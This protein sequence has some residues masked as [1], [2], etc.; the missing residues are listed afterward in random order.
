MKVEVMRIG[1][2]PITV[3]LDCDETSVKSVFSVEGSGRVLGYNSLSLVAAA[4]EQYGTVEAMGQIRIN[5][6]EGNLGSVVRD[7]DIIIIVPK[8]QGG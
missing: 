4:R 5:G 2:D 7:G 1:G 6:N 8:V 3:Q